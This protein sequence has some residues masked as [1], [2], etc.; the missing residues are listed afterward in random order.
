MN[1]PHSNDEDPAE[2]SPIPPVPPRP[3]APPNLRKDEANP[4]G[5]PLPPGIKPDPQADAAD[6]GAPDAT[7]GS[8]IGG[9]AIDLVVAFAISSALSI[10]NWK[11]GQVGAIAYLVSRDALPFL[12]GQ[13]IGKRAMKTRAV[14]ESGAS[15]SGNWSAGLLRNLPFIFIPFALR[16][17]MPAARE[18]SFPWQAWIINS[19]TLPTLPSC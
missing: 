13:S 9:F 18:A 5:S 19:P 4:M 3:V 15:L 11:F 6:P 14:T 10:F 7:M 12:D 1:D 17:E 16:P 8:R 2:P